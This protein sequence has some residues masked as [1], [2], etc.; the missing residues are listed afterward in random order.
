MNLYRMGRNSVVQFVDALGLYDNI[1]EAA[2]A[3]SREAGIK[4]ENF[5]KRFKANFDLNLMNDWEREWGGLVCHLCGEYKPTPARPG[6][7]VGPSKK[8]KPG[9][10]KRQLYDA[11]GND[12][13]PSPGMA[14]DGAQVD[15][16]SPYE[17]DDSKDIKDVSCFLEFGIG[18]EE[19]GNFHSHPGDDPPSPA[20]KNYHKYNEERMPGYR[21]FLTKPKIE[22]KNPNKSTIEV[23]EYD[24]TDIVGSVANPLPHVYQK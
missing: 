24:D 21:S 22:P 5:R 4:S 3:G 9:G 19:V 11:K 15:M 23:F 6:P 13:D 12:V 1:L 17:D 10:Q 8:P 18:W 14:P 20:D 7:I 16:H 2:A